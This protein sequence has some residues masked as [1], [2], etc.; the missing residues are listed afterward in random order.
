M[1]VFL[2]YSVRLK[3]LASK[4]LSETSAVSLFARLPTPTLLVARG[5]S[6]RRS[7]VTHA[8]TLIFPTDFRAKERLLAVYCCTEP[9]IFND[10]DRLC[11][12]AFARI[13]A[14][15]NHVYSTSIIDCAMCILYQRNNVIFISVTCSCFCW[16]PYTFCN[17]AVHYHYFFLFFSFLIL[18]SKQFL[19]ERKKRKLKFKLKY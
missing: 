4:S 17:F 6:T 1:P 12:S 14:A 16:F 15:T 11:L 9:C 2:K 10:D 5:F 13:S 18:T 3:L 8:V 7:Y 19:Q